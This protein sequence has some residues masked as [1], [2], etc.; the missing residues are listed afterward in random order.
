MHQA[1][2]EETKCVMD[3]YAQVKQFGASATSLEE[4]KRGRVFQG[5]LNSACREFRDHTESLQHSFL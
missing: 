4:F 5:I 3:K 2:S 1:L